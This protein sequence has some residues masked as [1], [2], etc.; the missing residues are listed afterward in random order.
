MLTNPHPFPFSGLDFTAKALRRSVT[1][2][3]EELS[4]SFSKAYEASLKQ[5]HNFVV[6]G[7]FAV[8]MKA[9]PYRKDFFAKLGSPPERVDEELHKWLDA[10]EKIVKQLQDFYVQGNYS[11]G[12]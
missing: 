4:V 11:K 2:T 7:A 3:S 10:L 5:Y 8:A 12:L 9:C 6:K 1:D